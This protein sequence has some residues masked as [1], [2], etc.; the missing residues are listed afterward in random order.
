M[1]LAP[2]PGTIIT[3]NTPASRQLLRDF[4]AAR[5]ADGNLIWDSPD[6]LPRDAWLRRTWQECAWSEP[7]ATPVLL[8]RWQELT[9]WEE[10]IEATTR[11]V[12][13]NSH[14]TASAALEAW[15][16]LHAWPDALAFDAASLDRLGFDQSDDTRAF[17]S[18]MRRVREE[19]RDRGWISMAELPRALGERLA[20][21]R[22][23]DT[24]SRI[25]FT[26]FD[27]IAT[28]DRRLF[29]ALGAREAARDSGTTRSGVN[30]VSQAVCRDPAAELSQAAA[31]ARQKLQTHSGATPLSLGIL[32][33]GL[34]SVAA[35]AERIFDDILHPALGVPWGPAGVRHFRRRH[36][37]RSADRGGGAPDAAPDRECAA[38]GSGHDLALAVPRNRSG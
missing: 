37:G 15:R 25:T 4:D 26:G 29:E 24:P 10:A 31:W 6:I 27:E 14:A 34:A 30:H 20:A 33:P 13:L 23:A 22:A 19:L 7:A 35:N 3:E 11:D 21:S 38:R 17:S 8:T 36:F 28:A 32:V 18:W 5:K 16:L 12:L 9:L 2:S 1:A